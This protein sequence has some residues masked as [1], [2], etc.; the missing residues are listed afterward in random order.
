MEL[1]D[2][3]RQSTNDLGSDLVPPTLINRTQT[4]DYEAAR[5]RGCRICLPHVTSMDTAAITMHVLDD[6]SDRERE[7]EKACGPT[8]SDTSPVFVAE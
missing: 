8:S 3:V 4:L 5:K 2:G 7:R 6:T 1:D